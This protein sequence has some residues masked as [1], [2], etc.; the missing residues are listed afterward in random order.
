MQVQTL[1]WY[2]NR[3]SD[4][5]MHM[6]IRSKLRKD[7]CGVGGGG[8]G[9]RGGGGGGELKEGGGGLPVA[10]K[11]WRLKEVEGDEYES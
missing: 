4:M 10:E 11:P 7:G 9:V 8:G 2:L 5:N 6:L 3:S 1:C